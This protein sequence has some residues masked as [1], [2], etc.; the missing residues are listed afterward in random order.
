[1][2]DFAGRSLG[3]RCVLPRVELL[4][5][6]VGIVG[7][8]ASCLFFSGIEE[9]EAIMKIQLFRGIWNK[10]RTSLEILV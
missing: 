7:V 3:E 5:V 10:S 4:I 2:A 6:C 9:E 8:V 1:L